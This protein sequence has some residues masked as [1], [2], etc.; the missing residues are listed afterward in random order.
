MYP[1]FQFAY[2]QFSIDATYSLMY[3]YTENGKKRPQ[4]CFCP[5]SDIPP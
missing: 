5:V 2:E 4:I 1:Y 3:S